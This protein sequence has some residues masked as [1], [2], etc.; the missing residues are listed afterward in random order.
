M[1]GGN[2]AQAGRKERLGEDGMIYVN[3]GKTIVKGAEI[4]VMAELSCII[5]EIKN[6]R[7]RKGVHPVTSVLQILKYVVIGLTYRGEG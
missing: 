2:L 7:V 4:D 6:D 5:K 3:E 1:P